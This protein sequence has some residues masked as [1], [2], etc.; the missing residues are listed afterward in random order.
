M[1]KTLVSCGGGVISSQRVAR[2]F[3]PIFAQN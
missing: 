3:Y 1:I 2:T